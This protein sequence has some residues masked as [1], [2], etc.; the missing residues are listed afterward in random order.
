[1]EILKKGTDC[2]GIALVFFCHDGACRFVMH[3]RGQNTR[4]EQGRWDIGGGA[5][6]YGD[7]VEETLRREV[8]EEYGTDVLNF[9]F[10]GY[11][12]VHRVHAG[13]PTHW[14]AL[15]FKVRVDP[16]Q[17]KNGEPHKFDAVEWFTFATI[18][19]TVHTT[20]PHFLG[21]YREKLLEF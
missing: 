18:P 1:M 21:V 14:V 16:E 17:V 13:E 9:E 3:K 20:I 5:L 12:D 2:I 8:K 6:E 7:T 4:D 11:R 19:E 10:L 15:D